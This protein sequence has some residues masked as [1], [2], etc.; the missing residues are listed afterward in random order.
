MQ[1]MI[2]LTVLFLSA[3]LAGQ[4]T[5]G[6]KRE[7]PYPKKEKKER[8]HQVFRNFHGDDTFHVEYCLPGRVQDGRKGMTKGVPCGC[9]GM[10]QQYWE[11]ASSECHREAKGDKKALMDCAKNIQGCSEFM[12]HGG[13]SVLF[14]KGDQLK[15]Q[16]YCYERQSCR[17]C[18]D[19]VA[20]GRMHQW[21][22]GTLAGMVALKTRFRVLTRQQACREAELFSYQPLSPM[23]LLY[24][25][26]AMLLR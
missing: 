12:E 21:H 4:G 17:C 2:F 20:A 19:K 8:K 24:V 16:V 13:D 14:G 22:M 1:R 25:S 5:L 26:G 18:D 7:Q 15:C 10:Y 9:I 6:G 3:L 23:D 11:K